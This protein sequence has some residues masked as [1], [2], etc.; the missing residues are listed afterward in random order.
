MA[1]SRPVVEMRAQLQGL[2]VQGCEMERTR[3][4]GAGNVFSTSAVNALLP[5]PEWTMIRA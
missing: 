3:D 5:H 4:K 1:L 2:Y